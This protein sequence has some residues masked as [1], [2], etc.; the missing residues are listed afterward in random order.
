MSIKQGVAL[1]GCNRTVPPWS[2]GCW[3]D[4]LLFVSTVVVVVYWPRAWP[5]GGRPPTRILS[6]ADRR[7]RAKQYCFIRRASNKVIMLC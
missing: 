7:P 4:H 3:T 5:G 6:D 1:T 2:V